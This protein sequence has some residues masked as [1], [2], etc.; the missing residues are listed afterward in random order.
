MADDLKNAIRENA[1]P[2]FAEHWFDQ[3]SRNDRRV[4]PDTGRGGF[5]NL[6]RVPFTRTKIFL[7]VSKILFIFHSQMG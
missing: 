3:G 5:P 2:V 6:G 7:R 1:Y 4:L